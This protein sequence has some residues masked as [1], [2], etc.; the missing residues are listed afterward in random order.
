MLTLAVRQRKKSVVAISSLIPL[1]CCPTVIRRMHSIVHVLRLP[2]ALL[3]LCSVDT[4]LL[5]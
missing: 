1:E 4:K 5:A 2:P 3:D